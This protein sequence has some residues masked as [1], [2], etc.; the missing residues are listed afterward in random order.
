[1][2]SQSWQAIG[3]I[4]AAVIMVIIFIAEVALKKNSETRQESRQDGERDGKLETQIKNMEVN[5]DAGFKEVKR[6][7]SGLREK[8]SGD[9]RMVHERFENCRREETTELRRVEERLNRHCNG[10]HAKDHGLVG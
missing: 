9:I 3:T 4:A 8:M 5:M 10:S 1:M 7:I 2:N 6:D